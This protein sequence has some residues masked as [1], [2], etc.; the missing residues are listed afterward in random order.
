MLVVR[1]QKPGS[2][3]QCYAAYHK[4]VN[5]GDIAVTVCER[6]KYTDLSLL[7]SN[8]YGKG[9]SKILKLQTMESGGFRFE[10]FILI[11]CR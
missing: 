4:T 6:K 11:K 1:L 5:N 3:S 7:C 10:N 8:F 9:I 2:S